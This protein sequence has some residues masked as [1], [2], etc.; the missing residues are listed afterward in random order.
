MFQ[1]I[2]FMAKDYYEILGVS[3][4]ADAREIKRAY[5]KLAVRFHPD[6][7]PDPLA[8]DTF[9]EIT[10]AYEI[11]GDV[12]SRSSYDNRNVNT[13]YYEAETP[14]HRPHRDPA[15]RRPNRPR[16]KVKSERERTLETMASLLPITHKIV[17][18]SLFACALLFGDIILPAEISK[19]TIV[20]TYVVS[21]KMGRKSSMPSLMLRTDRG[22]VIEVSYIYESI[23]KDGLLIS[24]ER[25]R[26]LSVTTRVVAP[27][28]TVEIRKS[29][30]RNF[31]FAPIMLLLTAGFG[32]Y[33]RKRIDY[34][35]NAGVV[36][37][38]LLILTIVI[39][40]MVH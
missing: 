17:L 39:Y 33:F 18:I 27:G 32:F 35:F 28:Q 8:A 3:Q 11:L 6:K 23:F 38:M 9:R 1:A 19:E 40:S 34:A 37:L 5:R 20:D 29:I 31:S 2:L 21:K 22:N 14:Q 26:L 7:N 30:Y 15:Y 10:E 12:A 36:S 16:V 4:H 24:I 13:G 25:T